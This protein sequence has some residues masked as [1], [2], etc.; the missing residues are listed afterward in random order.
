MGVNFEVSDVQD[1][2]SVSLSSCCLLIRIQNSPSP[3]ICLSVRLHTSCHRLDGLNLCKVSPNKCFPSQEQPWS[4]CLFTEIEVSLRQFSNKCV[5]FNPLYLCDRTLLL[6]NNSRE[7]LTP[8]PAKREDIDKKLRKE[9]QSQGSESKQGQKPSNFS[10]RLPFLQVRKCHRVSP[11]Q[12]ERYQELTELPAAPVNLTCLGRR[13]KQSNADI[14]L[15]S[16]QTSKR[17]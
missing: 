17:G 16:K 2:P 13:A 5:T 4:G 7:I 1:R 11:Q 15:Y 3:V 9:G 14:M 8:F 6:T 12:M 10:F